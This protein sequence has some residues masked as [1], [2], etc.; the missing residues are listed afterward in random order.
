MIQFFLIFNK[1]GQTRF[2]QYYTFQHAKERATL[3]G[4]VTRMFMGR[5]EDQVCN[6][7][8]HRNYKCVYKMVNNLV[9]MI[10][11]DLNSN[12]NALSLLSFIDVFVETLELYFSKL[13]MFN[14]EKVHYILD[15]MIMNGYVYE[16]NKQTITR[17]L[18]LMKINPIK[19]KD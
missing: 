10:A 11:T 15:E 14:L 4:E 2:A 9:Y 13:V 3:E 6:V 17:Q 8:E 5:R 7:F 18:A 19:E 1:L 12:E 16:T